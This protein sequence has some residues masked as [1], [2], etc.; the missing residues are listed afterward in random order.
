MSTH[1][2]GLLGTMQAVDYDTLAWSTS[3]TE[4][5]EGTPVIVKIESASS[6]FLIKR[7]DTSAEITALQL[8]KSTT[9]GW[10]KLFIMPDCD[11]TITTSGVT[12]SF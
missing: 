9:T 5:A 8:A 7:A 11:V 4:F 3:A 6:K 10:Q 12:P 2:V 1:S